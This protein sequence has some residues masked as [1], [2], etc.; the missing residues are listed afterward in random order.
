M[1]GQGRLLSRDTD[2]EEQG[3]TGSI[4][5]AEESRLADQSTSSSCRFAGLVGTVA[6]VC[7]GLVLLLALNKHHVSSAPRS[8]FAHESEESL[9]QETYDPYGDRFSSPGADAYGTTEGA[10][11]ETAEGAGAYDNQAFNGV[12]E[13]QSATG[14]SQYAEEVP[15]DPTF[16]G[17]TLF[18]FSLIFP[19]G[20]E[21]E[22]MMMLLQRSMGPFSCDGHNVYSNSSIPLGTNPVTGFTLMTSSMGEGPLEVIMGS[23][24]ATALNTAVFVRVWNAVSAAGQYLNFDWTVKLD[25]DCVFLPQRLRSILI[26]IDPFMPAYLENCRF[27]LHGPIEVANRLA[28]RAFLIG[29]SE[30]Y[31][32][33]NKAMQR[34]PM[35]FDD[36]LHLV[37][38][39]AGTWVADSLNHGFG[40]DEYIRRCLKQNNVK[41]IHAHGMLA[42]EACKTAAPNCDSIEAVAFHPFKD[43]DTYLTCMQNA[44]GVTTAW[45]N[46]SADVYR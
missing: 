11:Y 14:E 25:A 20:K 6:V 44:Q 23:R 12:S 13:A 39:D 21:F 40:E 34:E 43:G 42:E 16:S 3:L 33:Y 29:Q 22:L 10:A 4:D 45:Q 17:P 35:K 32:I 8:S 26:G 37:K 19:G 9:I 28:M 30:C 27:G 1:E 24:W 38:G 36:T 18:C 46:G 31:D 41:L 2:S 5:S 7:L 15:Y